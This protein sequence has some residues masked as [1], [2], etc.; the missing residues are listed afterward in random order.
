VQLWLKREHCTGLA[1][2]V[3]VTFLAVGG[4]DADFASDLVDTTNYLGGL[5]SLPT[6]MT[7]SYDDDES[8]FGESMAKL[9]IF[10]ITN[11]SPPQLYL[12]F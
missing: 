11:E 10:Q 3:P 5:E 9:I 4:L 6:V 8:A 12:C 7:T 1:T 2:G